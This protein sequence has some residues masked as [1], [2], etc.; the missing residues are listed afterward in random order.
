MKTK[1]FITC[2]AV[3]ASLAV[4]VCAAGPSIEPAAV[5]LTKAVSAKLGSSQTIKVTAK[6]TLDPKLG[7][8]AGHEKGPMEI[9][10]K[11]PNQF[12]ALQ[13]A[14][15]ETRELAFDGRSLCLMH[16]ELKHHA[17]APLRAGT[18]EQF[19]DRVDERFGF[20]PPV[21]E[22]LAQDAAKQLFLHV[23][24]AR[25]TGTEWV[26]WTRCQRLHYVQEGMTTDLWVG[27]KDKLPRR[28][29]L[30]FTDIEGNPQW[31]IK[32]SKWELNGPVD[33]AL[34]AKRPAGDSQQLQL[35]KSR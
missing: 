1:L 30:T 25:V 27:I 5:E 4:P 13:R 10:A 20:R 29:L 15:A 19:A 6:H 28:Y 11:R 2:L 8:G 24:S 21:A 12:Y 23:T 35:L 3:V 32:F 16:P 7:I 18:I 31:D 26:G 34:F 17:L 33:T 14:G 9:T 22:L